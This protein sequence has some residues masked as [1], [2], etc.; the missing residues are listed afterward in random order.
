M[1]KKFG[2]TVSQKSSERV[3]EEKFHKPQ[4]EKLVD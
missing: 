3:V 2:V 4:N 1:D